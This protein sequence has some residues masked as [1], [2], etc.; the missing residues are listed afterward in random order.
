MNK[1]YGVTIESAEQ[2]GMIALRAGDE[3]RT[4][5]AGLFG[6]PLP[7]LPFVACA[8]GQTIMPVACDEWLIITG[9]AS[10]TFTALDELMEGHH[11]A[12]AEVTDAYGWFRVGGPEARAVMAQVVALDLDAPYTTS[13]GVTVTTYG[14]TAI[15]RA[16]G[17]VVRHRC[18]ESYDLYV[19]ITHTRYTLTLLRACAGL[20]VPS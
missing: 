15:G 5:V 19:D 17:I 13:A 11:G 7:S 10:A 12:V 16:A 2:A 1:G 18:P 9:D 6:T 20:G 4:R 8:D 14:R 3:G